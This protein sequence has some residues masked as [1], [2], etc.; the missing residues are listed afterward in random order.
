MPGFC[1]IETSFKKALLIWVLNFGISFKITRLILTSSY[2]W[3]SL[4]SNPGQPLE[5]RT[6]SFRASM[7]LVVTQ[8]AL[9]WLHRRLVFLDPHLVFVLAGERA[10]AIILNWVLKAFQDKLLFFQS[11]I[12]LSGCL[13]ASQRLEQCYCLSFLIVL[14]TNGLQLSSEPPR[15]GPQ[16]WTSFSKDFFSIRAY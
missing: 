13:A 14:Q 5:G 2:R 9:N 15:Q 12:C 6:N 1:S 10:L 4:D 8:L 16:S 7:R 3:Q 11:V